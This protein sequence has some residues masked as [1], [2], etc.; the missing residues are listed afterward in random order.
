MPT[1]SV[2]VPAAVVAAFLTAQ[3]RHALNWL[4]G[5]PGL[6]TI[7][8]AIIMIV[9]DNASRETLTDEHKALVEQIERELDRDAGHIIMLLDAD[10][11]TWP[12]GHWYL[13]WREKHVD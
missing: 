10:G 6:D 7:D 11:I 12:D 9:M 2:T 3:L 4:Y 13:T 1:V 5:W 8:Y